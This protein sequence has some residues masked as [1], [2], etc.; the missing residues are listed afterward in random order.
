MAAADFTTVEVWTR[1]GLVTF[2]V[3]VVMCLR[4]RRVEIAG[5]TAHPD[6]DWMTQIGRNLTDCVDGFLR[7]SSYLII[8]RDTK[9][10]PLRQ[11]LETTNTEAVRLP[12]RSPNLNAHIERYFRSLKSECLDRTIFFGEESLGRALRQF[13][14]Y[15]HRERNHQGLNNWTIEPGDEVG[16]AGGRIQSRPRL[17]GMLRYYYREAA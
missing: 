12:P 13:N 16:K 17:G 10:L 5:I 2:Y 8:D 15:Y 11:I 1:S 4:T 6:S 3:F 9:H 14:E 7:D